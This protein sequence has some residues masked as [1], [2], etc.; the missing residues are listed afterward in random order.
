MNWMNFA[1]VA[2]VVA[3]LAFVLPWLAVS[4]NGT[5]LATATGVDLL[6]GGIKAANEQVSEDQLPQWWAVATLGLILLGLVLSFALK[7]LKRAA[8][9]IGGAATAALVLC[10]AGMFMMIGSARTEFEAKMNEAPEAGANE[11]FDPTEMQQAMIQAIRFETKFGYWLELIA[12]VGAAGAGFMAFSGRRTS[13]VVGRLGDALQ[14]DGDE[15]SRY[16]DAMPDKT[17]R[18]ALEEYVYRFPN[19]RF[20]GLARKRLEGLPPP[21]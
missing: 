21:V 5:P 2:K 20:V 7:P 9:G 18:T 12:L 1:R 10:A 19:G 15:D 8:A 6:T 11:F 3:L 16:W 17:D 13:A 4:C 14:G